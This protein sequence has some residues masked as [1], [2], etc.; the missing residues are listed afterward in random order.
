MVVFRF[1]SEKGIDWKNFKRWAANQWGIPVNSKIS[2][3]GD[4]LWMLVCSS[5]SEVQRI[6]ALNCRKFGN[7]TI[8]ME[9]WISVASRS[10]ILSDSEVTWVVI[11][12]IPLHLRS[13][14]LF[15]QL[16]NVCGGFLEWEEGHT[17]NFVRLKVQIRDTLP[18]V[19][20]LAFGGTIFPVSVLAEESAVVPPCQSISSFKRMWIS[21]GKKKVWVPSSATFGG[22]EDVPCSPGSKELRKVASDDSTMV[23][24]SDGDITVLKTGPPDLSVDFGKSAISERSRLE[25]EMS[26]GSDMEVLTCP[27]RVDLDVYACPGLRLV[28]NLGL[29]TLTE[30]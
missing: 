24:F 12:G 28:S 5:A 17:L 7:I 21:K 14:E 4:D 3:L 26:V 29:A 16:G 27:K 22:T 19:I 1:V 8:L 20:N 9:R 2:R 15:E 11:R 25:T 23:Y 18:E 13:V 30:K 10:S 6:L